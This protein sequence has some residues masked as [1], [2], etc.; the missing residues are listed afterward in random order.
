MLSMRMVRGLTANIQPCPGTRTQR[1]TEPESQNKIE[2]SSGFQD[3]EQV[4][5]Q[6]MNELPYANQSIQLL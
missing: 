1:E 4:E 3:E 2:F 5:E 6:S